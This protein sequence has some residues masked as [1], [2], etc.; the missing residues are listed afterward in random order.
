MLIW[1]EDLDKID[2]CTLWHNRLGHP[3]EDI[4]KHFV[5]RNGKGVKYRV[6]LPCDVRVL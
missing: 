3:L 5:L 2:T 4:V 1:M 6:G